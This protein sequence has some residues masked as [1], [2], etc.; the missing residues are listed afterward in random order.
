MRITFLGTSHGVPEP[1]RNCACTLIEAGEKKY[2]IDMGIDPTP[3][4][5]SRGIHPNQIDAIFVTHSHGDHLSGLV[6]FAHLCSWAF[7]KADPQIFLPEKDTTVD[8]LRAWM[9]VVHEQ[10]RES[11]R[12][13]EIKEGCIYD[14]GTL[15]V[16]AM[17]TG[18]IE[19][20]YAFSLEAEGR[21]VLFTGD[22]KHGDG[23]T[24]DYARYTADTK[25][26]LAV[27]ECAHFDAMQ[28]LE[29]IRKNPPKQFCFNH[30]SSLFAESCYHLRSE[31]RNEVPVTLLTDGYEI[32]L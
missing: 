13:T 3:G 9:I 23:P 11:L 17:K 32:R 15:R 30:Y 28:Y 4:L 20:A 5:I 16:T 6:P 31:L 18:H 21:R 1:N 22:M 14:D 12:F 10:L 25:Y 29:P 19:N 26:D 8:A 2:L 24:A 7:T 27:A